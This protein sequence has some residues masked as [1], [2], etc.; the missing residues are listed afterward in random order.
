MVRLDEAP[1]GLRPKRIAVAA[2]RCFAGLAWPTACR[3]FCLCALLR[4]MPPLRTSRGRSA[5]L[6]DME[7]SSL[8][9]RQGG[10]EVWRPGTYDVCEP[11]APA[12]SHPQGH[13]RIALALED[14][15]LLGHCWC[16]GSGAVV[17]WAPGPGWASLGQGRG[18]EWPAAS[19]PASR[20]AGVPACRL[21]QAECVHE[22][23]KGG[24]AVAGG[25]ANCEALLPS[26]QIPF[27]RPRRTF[28]CSSQVRKRESHRVGHTATALLWL[29][30][31]RPLDPCGGCSARRPEGYS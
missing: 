31:G 14:Q 27:P 20:R 22:S 18:C 3:R 29:R 5:V 19:R 6:L 15:A 1:P 12:I 24:D 16:S 9:F 11:I 25:G 8:D 13:P 7:S 21:R 30:M 2:D 17:C 28:V 23:G 4:S 26:S 10:I